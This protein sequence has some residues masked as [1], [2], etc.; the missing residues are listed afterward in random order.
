MRGECFLQCGKVAFDGGQP[1]IQILQREFSQLLVQM[2][3]ADKR[4]D[5]KD[6]RDNE[7]YGREDAEEFHEMGA[8]ASRN[9]D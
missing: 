4:G 7:D 6:R 1:R 2:L 9:T 8:R 5:G 3:N